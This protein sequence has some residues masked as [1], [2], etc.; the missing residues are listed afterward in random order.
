MHVLS[1]KLVDVAIPLVDGLWTRSMD[2]LIA[3]KSEG[4]LK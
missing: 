3:A 4:G 2:D 1:M